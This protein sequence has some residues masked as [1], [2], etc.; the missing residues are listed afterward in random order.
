MSLLKTKWTGRLAFALIGFL[1]VISG[2]S[3]LT[4]AEETIVPGG[5]EFLEGRRL[6]QAGDWPASM[7]AFKKVVDIYSPVSD[8]A[9]YEAAESAIRIG[10]RENAASNLEV[11]LGLYPDTPIR[12]IAQVRLASIYFEI[13]RLAP[14]VPLL[15]AAL[16]GAESKRETVGLTL[17]LA[18]AYAVTD[19]SRAN[20]LYWQII[21]GWPST[22]EALEAAELVG[23]VATPGN[24]LSIAKVYYLNKKPERA[25]VLLDEA[26]KHEGAAPILPELLL[27]KAHCLGQLGKKKEAMEFYTRIVDEHIQSPSAAAALYH[28]G[29]YLKS[30]GAD[31]EALEEFGR[32]LQLF[33]RDSLASQALLQRGRILERSEDPQAHNEYERI[34]SEYPRSYLA[35]PVTMRWGLDLFSKRNYSDARAVF[36][37]LKEADLNADANADAH[38]WI[39]KCA[40][41]EG[42]ESE[43]R[44]GFDEVIAR[45]QDSYQSFRARYILQSLGEIQSMYSLLSIAPGRDVLAYDRE[46]FLSF[47]VKTTE[48]AFTALESRIPYISDR[49]RQRLKFLMLNNLPESEWELEHFA[50][51]IRDP[52]GRYTLAWAF[53]QV[54]AYNDALRVASALRREFFEKERHPRLHYLL[55]PV[56]YPDL[57]SATTRKYEVNPLLTLAVM[58]EE[59][60]F[61]IDAVSSSNAHGLMQILPST[62]EWLAGKMFGPVSFQNSDLFIPSVNVEIGNYYLRYLLD[63]FDNNVVYAIAAYNWGE[64]NLRR[65]LSRTSHDDFDLFVESIP[66]DETRRYVKKVLRSLAVY[67]RLYPAGV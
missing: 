32:L 62:G 46:P 50:A 64:T 51:G 47:E 65:W 24:K 11:L 59:S 17:M 43:A 42:N 1:A 38:F 53:F 60:H 52:E 66:A 4:P 16:P 34:L 56:A 35:Y 13:G 61:R 7:E 37:M 6:Q 2:S 20:S 15:R 55:Y 26:L 9:L 5:A 23:K 48:E 12:R 3:A 58:R 33:P 44:K 27:Y 29:E 67:N 22:S 49:R 21:H 31:L 25:L 19:L 57:L 41:A 39:A 14:A 30:T 28:R 36:R 45:F 18:K 40:L 8:Y 54:K 63:K 10:D